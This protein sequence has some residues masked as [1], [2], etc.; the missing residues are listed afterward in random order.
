[1]NTKVFEN[2]LPT[3]GKRPQRCPYSLVLKTASRGLWGH[4]K[5]LHVSLGVIIRWGS[6][7]TQIA[8]TVLA[9]LKLA[10]N[11]IKQTPSTITD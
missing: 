1:M 9:R 8:Q 4:K 10:Q 5:A 7:G 11:M 6:C 2:Q 3:E